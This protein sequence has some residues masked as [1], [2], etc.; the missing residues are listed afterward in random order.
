[1]RMSETESMH[2]PAGPTAT[3]PLRS[4]ETSAY[5]L[6]FAGCAALFAVWWLWPF[7]LALSTVDEGI[8]LQGAVRILRGEIPY[9]DFFSFYT[10]GSYY[11]YAVVFRLFGTS[12]SSARDL[13]MVYAAVLSLITYLLARRAF[14]RAIALVAAVSITLVF[15]PAYVAVLHNWDSTFTAMLALYFGVLFLEQQRPTL[16]FVSGLF[17]GATL[18]IEQSKGAGLLL[19]CML[20]GLALFRGSRSDRKRYFVCILVGTSLPCIAVVTYFAAHH[21]LSQLL[22]GWCWAFYHESRANLTPYGQ[23]A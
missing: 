20:A 3:G 14:S 22:T 18:M 21:A 11:I 17:T 15:M 6:L 5:E 8:L 7:R 9:R 19:G 13:L 12:F 10:P 16:A 23:Q 1:M 2:A 4:P